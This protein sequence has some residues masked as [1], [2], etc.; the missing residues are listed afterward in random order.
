MNPR[1][2]MQDRP[3]LKPWDEQWFADRS[4]VRRIIARDDV[5]AMTARI[6]E[7]YNEP[8]EGGVPSRIR[9][10]AAAPDLYRALERL[11]DNIGDNDTPRPTWE[12]WKQAQDA[13]RKARGE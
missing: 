4:G 6:D 11:L 3:T 5:S 7:R 9:L 2:T 12:G 8:D 1:M 13:L 10:A